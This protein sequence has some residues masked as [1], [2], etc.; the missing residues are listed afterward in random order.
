MSNKLEFPI[1]FGLQKTGLPLIITSGKLKNLCFLIDTGATHNVLFTYV[2]KHFKN[3][4]RM[5]DEHQSTMGIE[6]NYKECPTIEATFTF[7]GI[8]YT[9]TF[10]VLDATNAVTQIQ[11]ETGVQIHGILSTDFFIQNKWIINFDK[12]IISTND[13]E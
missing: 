7:E 13:S 8:D 5:L 2:F 1:S 11:E 6:G 12:L 9:S 3:E 4:F 10:T